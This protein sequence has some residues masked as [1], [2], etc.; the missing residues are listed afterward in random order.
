MCG[1]P[2]NT[3]ED[4][5][6]KLF[7]EIF[8]KYLGEVGR[9]QIIAEAIERIWMFEDAY[10]PLYPVLIKTISKWDWTAPDLGNHATLVNAK[11][12]ISPFALIDISEED[13]AVTTQNYE[14][15][16]RMEAVSDKGVRIVR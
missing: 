9:S 14:D 11:K 5:S 3:G 2:D 1:L 7:R 13:I 8:D 6:P 16:Q 4:C 15:L 12:G 10:V